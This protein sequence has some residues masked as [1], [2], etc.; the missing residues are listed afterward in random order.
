MRVFP[1]KIFDILAVIVLCLVLSSCSK[2]YNAERALWKAGRH[3]RD[4][5]KN[6]DAIPPSEYNRTI[7]EYKTIINKFSG[8]GIERDA[9][10][11]L[12]QFYILKKD[13]EA[14]RREFKE[15]FRLYPEEKGLLASAQFALGN[16]YEK[17]GVWEQA[18]IEYRKLIEDFPNSNLALQMPIYIAGYYEKQREEAA[19]EKA[20]RDAVQYYQRIASENPKT[21][22]GYSAENLIVF[23]YLKLGDWEKAVEALET[24]VIDY[25]KSRAVAQNLK[26]ASD[27][28]IKKLDS[29]EKTVSIYERFISE[30]PNHPLSDKI[31][32][33]IE[34]LK[35]GAKDVIK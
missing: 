25:P 33:R 9:R 1:K 24:L 6:P 31:K 34:V 23:S 10:F 28:C 7:E 22:L 14:A 3:A 17:E 4:I 15:I 21:E 16:S 18:L 29:P 35:Q 30:N 2:E 5:A 11:G 26:L 20:F 13:Y 12:G 32:E 19:R 27:I 8:L